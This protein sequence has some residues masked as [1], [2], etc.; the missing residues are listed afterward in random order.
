MTLDEV[1][2]RAFAPAERAIAES[3]IPGAVLGILYGS[4]RIVRV[5]GSA[6]LVPARAP[7]RRETS[8]D[9]ASLTK[10]IFTT[11]A[12]LRLV[13]TG[14]IALDDPLIKAVPD[15]RQYDMNAVGAKAD[16]PPVPRAPDP[17]AGC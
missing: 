10:V 8:F 17:P 15:L 14:R 6:Q 4:E 9:L 11:T 16:L 3:R 2:A 1:T 12:V 7:M 5:A 13:E